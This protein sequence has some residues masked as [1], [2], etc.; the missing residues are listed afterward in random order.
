MDTNV[1]QPGNRHMLITMLVEQLE[2]KERAK[3]AIDIVKQLPAQQVGDVAK[4]LLQ[5]LSKLARQPTVNSL[6]KGL[7]KDERISMT[8]DVLSTVP[9][10]DMLQIVHS[11]S[12]AM[13]STQRGSLLTTVLETM[14]REEKNQLVT[15]QL[16]AMAND[17]RAEMLGSLFGLMTAGQRQE[18]SDKL[19]RTKVDIEE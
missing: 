19:A 17:D 4:H 1:L 10:G 8:S 18:I 14:P 2:E 15:E 6:I 13:D 11:R 7:S 12:T 9:L 16:V 5:G 3:Q